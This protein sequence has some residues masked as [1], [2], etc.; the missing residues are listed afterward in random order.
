MTRKYKWA[1]DFIDGYEFSSST[2]KDLMKWVRTNMESDELYLDQHFPFLA[3][4]CINRRARLEGID[5]C[6]QSGQ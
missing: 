5:K 2:K 6:H 4:I 1:K 3:R